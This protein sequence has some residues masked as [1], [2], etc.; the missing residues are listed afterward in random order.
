ML[1]PLVPSGSDVST[2]EDLDL[3]WSELH[4][5]DVEVDE[6]RSWFVKG[7]PIDLRLRSWFG[8]CARQ[9]RF[10][11]QLLLPESTTARLR[12]VATRI[13]RSVRPK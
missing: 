3:R 10:R 4:G 12:E 2:Q 8:I 1:S 7:L 13:S 11:P 5:N 6:I 9:R